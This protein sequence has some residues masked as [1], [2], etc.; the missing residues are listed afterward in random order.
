L[1]KEGGVNKGGT[2]TDRFRKKNSEEEKKKKNPGGGRGAG[3]TGDTRAPGKKGRRDEQVKVMAVI[4][5]EHLAEEE[6]NE[7]GVRGRWNRVGGGDSE[8][9]PRQVGKKQKNDEQTGQKR[10]LKRG[11]VL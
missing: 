8:Q 10:Q 7:K 1:S 5:Y 11:S 3:Q 9:Q 6:T 4:N 2:S